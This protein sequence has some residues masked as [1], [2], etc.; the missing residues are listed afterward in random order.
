[1]ATGQRVDIEGSVSGNVFAFAEFITISDDVGGLLLSAGS[2]VELENSTVGG[3]LAIADEKLSIDDESA[4]KG[5][6]IMAGNNAAIEGPIGLDL[7]TFSET[8]E[9]NSSV[10]QNMEAFGKRVR[11]LD[12]AH[13]AGSA[14]L[15]IEDKE[16][17]H[18][19]GGA[20]VDGEVEFL[21]LPEEFEDASPY[22]GI[23]FYLWQFARLASAILVGLALLWLV[24]GMRA[25]RLDGGVEGLKTAG[26]GLLALV[27]PAVIGLV[28]AFTL[29]GLPFTILSL[30]SWLVFIYLAKVVVGLF[31]GRTLLANTRFANSD[32]AILL[33]GLAAILVAVNLPAIGA[34]VSF[35]IAVLGI[36]LIVQHLVTAIEDRDARVSLD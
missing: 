31:V 6:A 19:A 2:S 14:R 20:I 28:L 18:R 7:Y 17:F 34:I 10:G 21:D 13:I 8:S 33:T 29:I 32:F 35:V 3:N 30:M 5:N 27:G 23:K 4:V 26:M 25:T 24:P 9:L 16:H 22:A 11:L 12:G 36:G 1:M 15:R